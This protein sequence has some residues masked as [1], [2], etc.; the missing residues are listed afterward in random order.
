MLIIPTGTPHSG[1]QT[2]H[3]AASYGEVSITQ[4]RSEAS[5]MLWKPDI[6]IS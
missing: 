3:N 1:L 5:K 2:N 4:A 6:R